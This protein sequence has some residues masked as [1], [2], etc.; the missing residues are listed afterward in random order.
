M[1]IYWKSTGTIMVRIE[2]ETDQSNTITASPDP[3]T[4]CPYKLQ[5]GASWTSNYILRRQGTA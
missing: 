4:L 5:D 3:E 2:H 1:T